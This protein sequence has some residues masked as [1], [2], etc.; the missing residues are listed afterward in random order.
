MAP[1]NDVF[2]FADELGPT[3]VVHV[4]NPAIGL[5]A[6]LVVDN[7]AAGPSIGGVRMAP[8]VSTEECFR[9]ARAMTFK[10]A[11]A[12]LAHGGGK[13][14]LYG[15]PKMPTDRKERLIR[16]LACAL[17]DI[18]DYIFGP[19]MGTDETCMAWVKDEIGRAV[20]LPREL[21]GIPLDEI[22]ATGWGVVHAAE[23]A[24]SYCKFDL[25]GAR[26][27]IQGYGAVGRHAARFLARKGAV[28]IA[29]ADSAGTIVDRA[30][31]DLALLDRVKAEGKSVLE[32]P[33]GEKR[34]RDAVVDIECEIWIPAARP[35]VVH[36]GN[37][38]RLKT[39]LVVQG[40]N[41]PFTHGAEQYLHTK[42]VLCV[43]DFIANAGGVICAAVEYDGG[44]QSAALDTIAEK[45]RENTR[46]VLDA[47]AQHGKLP[48]DAA[49]GLALERVKKAMSLRR[50]GTY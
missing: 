29:A 34:E 14:V 37:V 12:G 23:I 4:H 43:P 40:A 50:W 46:A 1:I 48:R 42:G 6:V 18:R 2:S 24:A 22:G 5:R 28:V 30:G 20:G 38:A 27:V 9:L 36:E 25:A 49:T 45:V 44:R 26:V 33:R 3:K 8:D 41:I 15:D 10:N 16:G 13:V 47:A 19:D 7:V 31:L 11:A 32:Y 39:R 35:D 21:G 17:A